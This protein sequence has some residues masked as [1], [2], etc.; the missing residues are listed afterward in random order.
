MTGAT[1]TH[2]TVAGRA[3]RGF[4]ATLALVTCALGALLM[5]TWSCCNTPT[6]AQRLADP[7]LWGLVAAGV[8]A[9]A[10][11]PPM[12]AQLRALRVRW[13]MLPFVLGALAFCGMLLVGLVNLT[14]VDDT[15]FDAGFWTLLAVL[16]PNLVCALYVAFRIVLSPPAAP[17]A[18]T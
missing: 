10:S 6:T 3:V 17:P 7:Q 13:L 18:A 14:T 11:L 9:S 8:T 15:P 1:V 16:V 5:L 2:T 4:F 12:T